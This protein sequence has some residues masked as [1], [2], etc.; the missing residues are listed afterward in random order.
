MNNLKPGDMVQVWDWQSSQQA[1][2]Q[3]GL[4]GKVGYVVKQASIKESVR[5]PIWEIIFFGDGEPV[6]TAIN[7]TWL[8][9]INKAED[10]KVKKNDA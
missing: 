2:E 6:K 10:I 3:L 5:S 4:H 9:K 8:V 1:L 7:S